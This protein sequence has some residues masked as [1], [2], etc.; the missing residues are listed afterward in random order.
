MFRTLSITLWVATIS[1]AQAPQNTKPFV[2]D[3]P[4]SGET[5]LVVEK[6]AN[7]FKN[8]IKNLDLCKYDIVVLRKEKEI[9]IIF[10]NKN[11]PE[12]V[13]GNP[14]PLPEFEV[15]INLASN[16][17]TRSNFVR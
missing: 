5:F 7:V 6:A 1:I 11:R 15:T 17:I 9:S 8:K 13:L 16:E 3:P 10:Q 4:I 12:G 14:G 2:V